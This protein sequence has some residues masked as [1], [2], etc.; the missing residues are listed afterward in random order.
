MLCLQKLYHILP[1]LPR[2]LPHA[3][4]PRITNEFLLH[5]LIAS[6]GHLRTVRTQIHSFADN[7]RT[8]DA[9]LSSGNAGDHAQCARGL[10]DGL[11]GIRKS[12]GFGD[13]AMVLHRTRRHW[14]VC[15]HLLREPSRPKGNHPVS[16]ACHFVHHQTSR[17][18]WIGHHHHFLGRIHG[19]HA[20]LHHP[21]LHGQ[22]WSIVRLNTQQRGF[23]HVIQMRLD[24][25]MT[26]T[27]VIPLVVASPSYGCQAERHGSRTGQTLHTGLIGE[28]S[29]HFLQVSQPFHIFG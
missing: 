1:F 19:R 21:S 12:F 23:H 28:E 25:T 22:L 7:I 4:H 27:F 24:T 13:F 3:P 6:I 9:G 18:V 8:I 16:P 10:I 2:R 15:L 17:T 5:L 29:V 11:D 14:C 26:T 20:F